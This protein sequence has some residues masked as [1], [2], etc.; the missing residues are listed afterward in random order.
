MLCVDRNEDAER[1]HATIPHAALGEGCGRGVVVR[2]RGTSGRSAGPAA[3][4][5]CRASSALGAGRAMGLG[6]SCRRFAA[7]LW[8]GG[9][10]YAKINEM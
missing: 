4:R 6:S 1:P 8:I 9:G 10:E 2:Q 7:A 5:L 3:A